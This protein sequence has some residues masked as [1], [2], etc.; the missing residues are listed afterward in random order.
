M[1]NRTARGIDGDIAAGRAPGPSAWGH[2]LPVLVLVLVG[3]AVAL[4]LTLVQ[5]G[6]LAPWDPV[7]GDGT[8]RVLFSSL[9]RSLPIPDAG[10]GAAAYAV[11]AVLLVPGGADRWT[12]R[13]G[14]AAALGLLTLAMAAGGIVLI[15]VQGLVIG[16]FCALCL[17]S[18]LISI[19]AAA[20]DLPELRAALGRLRSRGRDPSPN[21]GR[22]APSTP[23]R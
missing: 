12:T 13:P 4:D 11:E 6:V 3:L 7:F 17:A 5:L 10:L 15:L 2:R 18:A 20:L 9:A 1:T 23:H 21:A 16:A 8:R 14:L 19:A 22:A